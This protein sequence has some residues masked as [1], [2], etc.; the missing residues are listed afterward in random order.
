[1]LQVLL[2]LSPVEISALV[3]GGLVLLFSFRRLYAD[4]RIRKLGAV[5]SNVLGTNPITGKGCKSFTKT[6]PAN[7]FRSPLLHQGRLLPEQ[8]QARLLLQPHLRLGHPRMPQLCRDYFLG[9]DPL[10]DDAGT[11]T[12]QDDTHNEVP[13]VWQG[14]GVPRDLEPL[15]GRL[16]LHH[17]RAAMVGQ[18]G[19]DP[20]H[21][22]QGQG[23]RPRD[24]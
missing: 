8:G 17:R 21:V 4:Y 19:L 18:Q 6:T 23:A 10:L 15:S 16:N 14:R 7:V 3:F 1:M 22:R 20:A 11:R 9:P 2:Q 13:R 5:R 24:L 12:Y